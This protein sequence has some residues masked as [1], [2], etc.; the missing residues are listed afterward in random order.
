MMQPEKT[1]LH[2]LTNALKRFERIRP[3]RAFHDIEIKAM[4]LELIYCRT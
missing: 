2:A 4:G 1:S 3:H